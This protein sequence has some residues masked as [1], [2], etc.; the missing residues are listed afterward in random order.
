MISFTIVFLGYLL[1]MFK[2]D[3]YHSFD[4]QHQKRRLDTLMATT[5]FMIAVCLGF[6]AQV[7]V[8]AAMPH[9]LVANPPQ[10]IYHLALSQPVNDCGLFLGT[11][12][13]RDRQYLNYEVLNDQEDLSF[14]RVRLYSDTPVSFIKDQ[15]AGEF[16]LITKSYTYRYDWTRWFGLYNYRTGPR[17]YEFHV[18]VNFNP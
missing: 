6:V 16:Q 4:Y 3:L 7:A 13:C 12:S 1:L 11:G 5:N 2:F 18:P 15:K 8:T 9:V 17:V 14:K 10:S